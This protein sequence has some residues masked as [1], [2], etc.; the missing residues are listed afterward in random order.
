MKK[1]LILLTALLFTVA[2]SNAQTEKGTQNLGLNLGLSTS[3]TEE[4]SIGGDPST[5]DVDKYTQFN[6]GPSYSYFVADKLDIGV[7]LSYSHS[8]DANNNPDQSVVSTNDNTYYGALYARKYFLFT[9]KFGIRTGP[10]LSFSKQ[11]FNNVYGNLPSP[12]NQNSSQRDINAGIN[13]DLVYYASKRL[14]FSVN[15]ANLAYDHSTSSQG[16]TNTSSNEFGFNYINTGLQFSM[17]YIF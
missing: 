16:P 12:V 11:Q 9:S 4:A 10:Y 2:L 8:A 14:G 1:S 13:L 7:R 6:I 17:F 3:K 15:L 5:P